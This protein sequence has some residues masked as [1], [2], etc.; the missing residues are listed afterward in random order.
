MMRESTII[1]GKDEEET[2]SRVAQAGLEPIRIHLLFLSTLRMTG[3]C[4]HVLLQV[5]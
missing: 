2:E 1:N 3:M 4:H 5:S